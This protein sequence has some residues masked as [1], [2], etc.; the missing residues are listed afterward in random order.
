[1]GDRVNRSLLTKLKADA[2]SSYAELGKSVHLSAPAVY[3][4]VRRMESSGVIL[5]HTVVIDPEADRTAVLR[6]RAD[7]H[8]GNL[9]LR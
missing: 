4:R 2:R 7:C 3:E 9:S 6:V 8:Q 1:M 5:G